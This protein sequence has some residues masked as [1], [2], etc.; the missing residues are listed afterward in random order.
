MRDRCDG[1]VFLR[2]EDRPRGLKTARCGNP[3]PT[4]GTIRGFGR[5]LEVSGAGA[6]VSVDRPAWCGGER[7]RIATPA[8]SVTAEL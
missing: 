8:T 2:Y 6:I 5:T 1:C 7:K 3:A 4:G